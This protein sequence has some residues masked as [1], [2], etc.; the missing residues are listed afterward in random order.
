MNKLHLLIASAMLTVGILATPAAAAGYFKC[1]DKKG[2][3]HVGNNVER[4]CRSLKKQG[5]DVVKKACKVKEPSKDGAPPARERCERTCRTCDYCENF[6]STYFDYLY[7]N[8]YTYPPGCNSTI[9]DGAVCVGTGVSTTPIPLYTDMNIT[10]AAN[11]T[12]I[13]AGDFVT[14]SV[15][16]TH[17]AFIFEKLGVLH[18]SAV[19][20]IELPSAEATA[21]G[22]T[23]FFKDA[24]GGG[25]LTL[26][27]PSAAKYEI[28]LYKD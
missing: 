14:N 3:A 15:S 21:T 25:S 11:V 12:Y 9:V 22:G 18:F 2:P 10:N 23:G 27:Y 5:K 17:G 4:S 7:S 24:S 1:E 6:Y 8:V 28:C 19:V 26:L 16:L 20:N 13:A